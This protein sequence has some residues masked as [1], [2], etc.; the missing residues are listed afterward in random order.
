MKRTYLPAVDGLRSVAVMS[1]LLFH[2]G[3]SVFSGGY[4]G[5]DVFFVISGYLITGHL[6]TDQERGEFSF[7]KFYLR[8]ARRLLPAGFFTLAACLL[9]GSWLLSPEHLEE[10]GIS[11]VYSLFSLPNIYFWLQTGYWDAAAETKPLLHFWSLGVEEQFY[12]VWPA[13]L[14]VSLRFGGRRTALSIIAILSIGSL[15]ASEAMLPDHPTAVFY[16]TPFRA[17]EFCIGA[18]LAFFPAPSA[19]NR[20]VRD[21]IFALGLTA[22]TTAIFLYNGSTRFPGLNAILPCLG[23]AMIIHIARAPGRLGFILGNPVA[24]YLGKISYSVYLA[25]WPIIVFYTYWRF[26]ELSPTESVV[27]VLAAMAAGALMYHFIEQPFRHPSQ[28]QPQRSNR[29]FIAGLVASLALIALPST[30]AWLSGGWTSRYTKP[31]LE[32]MNV[33]KLAIFATYRSS[34]CYSGAVGFE[35]KISREKCLTTVPG[36]QNIILLGDS[37]AAHLYPGLIATFP[38]INIM[39]GNFSSCSPIMGHEPAD[40][41]CASFMDHIY[42]VDLPRIRPQN[43]ILAARWSRTD[44]KPLRETIRH[45]KALGV[46]PII[47]GRSAEYQHSLPDIVQR[48]GVTANQMNTSRF[49]LRGLRIVNGELEALAREEEVAYFDPLDIFCTEGDICLI[50][51]E[52][53]LLFQWDSGHLTPEGSAFLAKRFSET[54]ML[55]SSGLG[56]T[57]S[58]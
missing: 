9:I 34:V 24:V 3:F 6:L 19:W 38:S 17:F 48:R 35:N 43:A 25:H 50:A 21:I 32:L 20:W 52:M 23:A 57:S 22:V 40:T 8:R 37:H 26:V 31:E 10:L 15:C 18:V 44:I 51:E 53:P 41:P 42:S 1:V 49:M 27:L 4:V 29:I 33:D 13:M 5:V 12:L 2:A 14:A 16:L 54:G 39:Q 58:P 7:G 46:K 11:S 47:F 30:G 45:L 56:A 28:S 36:K 55:A